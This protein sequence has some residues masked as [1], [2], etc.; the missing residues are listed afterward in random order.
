MLATANL[1]QVGI[2]HGNI[3]SGA[4]F[5]LSSNGIRITDFSQAQRHHCRSSC[6][7]LLVVQERYG[8]VDETQIYPRR[9]RKSS[10]YSVRS[11]F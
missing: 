5:V 3:L 10:M 7:E 2:Y 8:R 4:H 11:H 6:E 9:M 1:H